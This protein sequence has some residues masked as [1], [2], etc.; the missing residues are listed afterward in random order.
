V[1]A[2]LSVAQLQGLHQMQLREFGGAGGARDQG[3]LDAAAACG[4]R[5]RAL[6]YIQ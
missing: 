5:L 6:G 2:Y 4:R 3:G 1:T